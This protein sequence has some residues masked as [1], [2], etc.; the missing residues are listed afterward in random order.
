MHQHD[1]NIERVDTLQEAFNAAEDEYNELDSC[2]YCVGAA[3]T[4]EA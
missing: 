1:K 2:L 4:S 3:R